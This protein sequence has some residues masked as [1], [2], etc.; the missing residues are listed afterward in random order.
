MLVQACFTGL[1]RHSLPALRSP[2]SKNWSFWHAQC[3]S[4][5]RSAHAT[6]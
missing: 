2:K 1:K 5:R 6:V 4:T 3:I